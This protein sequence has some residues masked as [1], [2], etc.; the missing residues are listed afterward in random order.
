[1]DLANRSSCR[2]CLRRYCASTSLQSLS[3]CVCSQL[4]LQTSTWFSR[5]VEDSSRTVSH[6]VRHHSDLY[7]VS[8]AAVL[9]SSSLFSSTRSNYRAELQP[10]PRNATI[11]QQCRTPST[12]RM[13][14]MSN[15]IDQ[16]S[17][18][19]VE[20]HRPTVRQQCRIPLTNCTKSCLVELHRRTSRRHI[21]TASRI[22]QCG[23]PSTTASLT[24]APTVNNVELHRQ[25]AINNVEL[26]HGK[27]SSCAT[28]T[29][30]TCNLLSTRPCAA[31]D[32]KKK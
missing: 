18:N 1:M 24:M 21:V 2:S 27:L 9:N 26:R 16:P 12:N 28:Y 5:S 7:A 32:S 14:T 22:Q 11:C 25:S 30:N 3:Q 20:L 13:S 23:T 6:L 19:N 8:N 4:D 29:L 10:T 17:D 31:S 15:S